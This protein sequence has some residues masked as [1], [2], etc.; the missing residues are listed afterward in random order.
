MSNL[1]RLLRADEIECRVST[2]TTKGV[3]LLLYKDARCDMNILDE[4]FGA[5]NW[6][7]EFYEAKGTLFCRVGIRVE[8]KDGEYEWVFKGD[9]GS[10]SNTEAIKGE[11]SDARKR[12][13]FCWGI[14]RELYTAPFIWIKAD[15]INW[16]KDS[17]G[18]DVPDARF[19]VSEIGYDDQRR[20]NHLIVT[21][22]GKQVYALGKK[23]QAEPVKDPPK[24]PAVVVCPKC[25]QVVTRETLKGKVREP[26]EIL[27]ACGGMCLGCWKEARNEG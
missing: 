14:G 18:K 22:N 19:A 23:V 12:A 10:P 7:D 25:G 13:G 4:T 26:E 11:A 9:A 21:A 27:K 20:I 8:R 17:R 15:L 5:E 6:T 3:S 16:K 2:V 1:F 24:T